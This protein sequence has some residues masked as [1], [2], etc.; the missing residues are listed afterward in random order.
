MNEDQAAEIGTM[1]SAAYPTWRLDA[2]QRA[3]FRRLLLRLRGDLAKAAV[4]E[5]IQTSDREFAPPIGLIFQVAA[6]L[7]MRERGVVPLSAE[8]GWAVVVRA[9]RE[10][11]YY[12]EPHFRHPAVARAVEALGWREVCANENIEATRAHFFRI[13]RAMLADEQDRELRVLIGAGATG[14]IGTETTRRIST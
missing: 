10:V 11:G 3:M 8:E 4:M 9:M 7:S 13:F 12:R 6:K 2:D 5:I 14:V 1:L